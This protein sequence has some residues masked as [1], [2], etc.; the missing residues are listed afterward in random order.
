M[1]IPFSYIKTSG[2]EIVGG[3]AVYFD[4][5][6]PACFTSG[7]GTATNLGSLSM[8]VSFPVG[9][10][11][12]GVHMTFTSVDGTFTGTGI[13]QDN[14]SYEFWLYPTNL[15]D[16]LLQSSGFGATG[17]GIQLHW[18][19]FGGGGAG[20][21]MD[22]YIRG[23]S[24]TAYHAVECL[25]QNTW[26]HVV[27]T[28]SGTTATLYINGSLFGSGTVT[29]ITTSNSTQLGPPYHLNGNNIDI[30][31]IYHS[32]LTADEVNQNFEAERSIFGV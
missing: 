23:S 3:Y 28:Y 30:W 11:I 19:D 17:P 25:I 21:P 29:A 14:S 13:D 16:G 20:S 2:S 4:F 22:L 1:L 31:R 12:S 5:T 26:Q 8:T 18:V 6:D 27:I 10:V 7:S 9:W 24:Y 15:T 32:V